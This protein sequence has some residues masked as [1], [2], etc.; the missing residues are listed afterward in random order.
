MNKNSILK[1][2]KCPKC[3]SSDLTVIIGSGAG[4]GGGPNG[5]KLPPITQYRVKCNKCNEAF[6]SPILKEEVK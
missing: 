5:V 3:G 2:K 4:V 1:D 6:A